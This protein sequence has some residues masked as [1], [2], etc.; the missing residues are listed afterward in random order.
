MYSINI[1]QMKNSNKKNQPMHQSKVRPQAITERV[2]KQLIYAKY[3]TKFI[4]HK[5]DIVQKKNMFF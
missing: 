5:Q 2:L 4:K 3:C 1:K